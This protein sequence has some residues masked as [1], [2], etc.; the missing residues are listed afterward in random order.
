MF[1]Q[2]HQFAKEN[3]IFFIQAFNTSRVDYVW[4]VQNAAV[5]LLTGIRKHGHITPL[6]STAAF[7]MCYNKKKVYSRALF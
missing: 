1:Y 5:H 2:L 7:K 6:V 3:P 4:L